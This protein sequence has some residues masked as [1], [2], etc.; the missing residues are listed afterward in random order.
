MNTVQAEM[1]TGQDVRT[2]TGAGQVFGM[3]AVDG[4][5][6]RVVDAFRTTDDWYLADQYCLDAPAEIA[7]G[8]VYWSHTIGNRA[9]L[10][11]SDLR[12]ARQ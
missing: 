9:T 11:A 5:Q 2:R 4:P 12:G 10:F 8:S 3:L 6:P 7:R 1:W